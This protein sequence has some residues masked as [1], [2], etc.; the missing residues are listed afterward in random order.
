MMPRRDAAIWLAGMSVIVLMNG[1]ASTPGPKGDPL[2]GMNRA[3][4]SFNEG[5]DEALLRPVATAYHDVLPEFVRTS[6]ENFFNN[7]NDAWSA[8]NHLLQA[9]PAAALEMGLRFSVNTVFGLGFVNVAGA[10]IERRQEDFGQTLGRWGMPP[11]PYLVLPILGPSTLRDTAGLTL[12]IQAVPE[13]FLERGAG[14]YALGALQVISVRSSLLAATRALDELA[15]DKYSLVRDGYLARRRNQVHD[16]NPP[17]EPEETDTDAPEG[18]P[19][20]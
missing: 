11:G 2:E 13:S 1:C 19:P 17:E 6:V 9:K 10:G 8:V 3:V 14:R 4:F 5:F 20:K 16:G 7:F 18:T 12:D 15:L